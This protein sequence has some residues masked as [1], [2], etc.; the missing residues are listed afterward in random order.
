MVPELIVSDFKKSLKFYRHTLGFQ[1][2]YSRSDPDFAYLKLGRIQL[3]LEAYDPETWLTAP[4]EYPFGRGINFQMEVAD[5]HAILER[6]SAIAYPLFR[7]LKENWY[8]TSHTTQEGQLEFLIQDP[9]G[10]LLR[11][12]QP[13]GSRATQT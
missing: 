2:N 3:M 6:L 7:P 5:V 1:E 9:D 12:I 13:L 10:Y 11:F 4:L 8:A